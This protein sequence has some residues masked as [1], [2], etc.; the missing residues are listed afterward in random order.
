MK[1]IVSVCHIGAGRIGFTL[2][3]DKKRIKPASHI[4]MWE[5]NKDVQLTGVCEKKDIKKSQLN[6][7]S[8]RANIYKDYTKMIKTEMPDI[9]SI[10]T[11]K[12]T[13]FKI[14]NKCI[15]LGVK[16]IVLEKP[17][18]NNLKQARF[19]TKKIKKKKIK[20][21]VNHRRRFDEEIIKLKKQIKSGIIGDIIQVSSYY[22]YGILTTG[23]HLVDTLRMVLNDVA[24]EIKSATGFKNELNFYHPKDDENIDGVLIFKNNLK[25]TIQ[26]LDIKKY[27]NFDIYLYGTKG[28][29]LISGI[30][31]SGF[32]YKV[33]K[34]PEHKGFEELKIFPKRIFGPRPRN[35]FGLLAE[36]AVD[37][38]LN[39]NIK[40]NCD[41][42]DS[43]IDMII[44]DALVKSSK[45]KNRTIKLN[46]NK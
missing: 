19:L 20:V 40:P 43:F 4:G 13:H 29:I 15:D 25:A 30:G 28:K 32:L 7:I 26:S 35:Q 31:R 1:K 42:K 41:D 23:T 24:G 21:L 10:S 5:K 18:A 2:E 44:I 3:F 14:T 45:Q 33:I 46:L 36:N 6:K 22:V 37:C 38:L 12:D 8:K 9:V 16:V 11:W 17:L 27:D 39:K 34:S